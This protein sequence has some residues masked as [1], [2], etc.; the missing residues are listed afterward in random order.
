MGERRTTDDRREDGRG[1]GLDGTGDRQTDTGSSRSANAVTDPGPGL[2]GQENGSGTGQRQ[3]DA[4]R[5]IETRPG[6]TA[7][8]DPDA[9]RG[10]IEAAVERVSTV[11]QWTP[12]SPREREAGPVRAHLRPDESL[13]VV[14][15]GR[16]RGNREGPATVALTDDRL[17]VV[18]EDGLVGTG[19]D[20][21]CS[22]RSS[23]GT[24]LGV[25]GNDARLV[26]G[27][28]YL[29]S[30]VGFL[31]VLGVASD[32]LT[33]ALALATVGGLLAAAHVRR[34]GVEVNGRT[35]TDRLRRFGA[36]DRLADGFVG[37]ERRVTGSAGQDPVARWGTAALALAPFAAVV[38]LEGG[39]LAP[40]LTLGMAVSFGAVLYAVR[41]SE[42]FDGVEVVRRRQRTVTATVDDGSVVTV[43]THPDSQLD[44][45]LA[46]RLGRVP[47]GTSRRGDD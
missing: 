29:L 3:S 16:L 33:P 10:V 15:S 14:D 46:A 1:D 2:S 28:G 9:E 42:E 21:L 24:A 44:S 39:V 35:L 37:V 20:R 7:S 34:E 4:A 43:T 13:Q 27:L 5:S 26:G 47:V 18:A 19:L 11:E 22:V 30:V 41:H 45:E 23:L 25:R 12:P 6:G 40:L 32:P 17:L 38:A 36:V 8:D 31:A